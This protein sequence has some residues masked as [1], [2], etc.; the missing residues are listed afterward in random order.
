MS[1]TTATLR[2]YARKIAA[3][4]VKITAV[5]EI[6]DHTSL[7]TSYL[8]RLHRQYQKDGTILLPPAKHKPKSLS[9]YHRNQKSEI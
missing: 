8:E 7:T 5:R 9:A 1:L 6:S 3:A 2:S 4:P